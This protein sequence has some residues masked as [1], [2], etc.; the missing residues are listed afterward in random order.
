MPQQN[1]PTMPEDLL[2]NTPITDETPGVILHDFQVL[3]DYVIEVSPQLTAGHL[4]PMKVLAQL[5]EQLSRRI[6]HDLRRPQQ[7]SYPHING[8]FLLLRASGL[9]TVDASG[10]KPVLEVDPVVLESW[11]GLNADE[12]YFALLESWLLRGDGEI[13]GE[14]EIPLALRPP[15]HLWSSLY[16][17]IEKQDWSESDWIERVRYWPGLYNLALMELFGLVTIEDAAVVPQKGWQIANIQSTEWG[18]AL[19][20]LILQYSAHNMRNLFNFSPHENLPEILTKDIISII[21]PYR[22]Q[23]QKTLQLPKTEFQDG[24]FVFKVLLDTQVWRM[25]SIPA[26]CTLDDLSNAILA[27]YRF[28]HDHLYRYIYSTRFGTKVQVNHPYLEYGLTTNEVRVGDLPAQP[29]FQ[30]AFNYDFGDDWYFYLQLEQIDPPDPK[31]ST[32]RIGKKQGKSP[33]QYGGW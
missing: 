11:R 29:G 21:Q 1:S 15:H 26:Q 10:R 6:Q 4:L 7:K 32:Y 16:Q 2:R 13:I 25:V 8:L 24:L 23:C 17:S 33:A 18:E 12:R 5:H 3:L 22:P 20:L 31:V 27:A 14:R 28:D 9:T 30:M 19:L